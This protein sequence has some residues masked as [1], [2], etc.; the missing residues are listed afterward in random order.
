MILDVHKTVQIK[1]N[2]KQISVWTYG[3][4]KNPPIFFIHGYFNAFSDYIGDLPIKY[5]MKDY[6]VVAFDLPGF[7]QAKELEMDPIVFISEVQKQI[8]KDKKIIL[9]GVSYGGL[10]SLKYDYAF[11]ERV[12]ALI[13]AGTPYFY[14]IFNLYKLSVFLPTI[15]GKKITRNIFKDFKFLSP[16]NLA[17]ISTPVLLYYNKAD[18]I[19][20]IYMGLKLKNFL[21]NSNIF[22]SSKQNHSWLLHRID[23]NGFLTEIKKF[24]TNAT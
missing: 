10:I 20:N 22:I 3:N 17:K 9:F 14:K 24:L 6:F 18:Y 19:A 12:S 1:I 23:Q 5:L 2:D 4:S 21:P 15:K 7:G 8:V 13:I 11:P 16:A